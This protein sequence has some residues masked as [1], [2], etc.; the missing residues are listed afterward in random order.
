MGPKGRSSPKTRNLSLI[1]CCCSTIPKGRTV[2]KL[3]AEPSVHPQENI[4]NLNN[5]TPRFHLRSVGSHYFLTKCNSPP[6]F[7][8]LPCEIRSEAYTFQENQ[9]AMK[10]SKSIIAPVMSINMYCAGR[11]L[12]TGL[13]LHF[14]L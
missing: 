2:F 7:Q 3:E 1:I 6:F 4:N 14:R 8:D 10:S 13:Y 9:T 11:V 5:L 12:Y